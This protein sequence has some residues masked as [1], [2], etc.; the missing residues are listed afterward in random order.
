MSLGFANAGL[1][2]SLAADFEKDACA[3]YQANLGEMIQCLDLAA[4]DAKFMRELSQYKG[5]FALIG[6][7]P[8]QGF[9]SAGL[10]N[11][12][13]ARNKLI[14]SYLN[15]VENIRPRW[16]LFENVEGLLTSNDGHSVAELVK[17]F[18]GVGYRVRLEKINF[19]SYGLPQ[20]RKRVVL[21]GNCVGLDFQMP[22][23]TH[24]YDAG[25]HRTSSQLPLAPSFD[26]ATSGL[27]AAVR[28]NR[29]LAQYTGDVS[30]PYDSLMR[31]GNDQDGVDWHAFDE[32]SAHLLKT[33]RHLGEGQTMKDL[34]E[35]FWHESFRR[36]AFR[37]VSDGTPT[38][39]RGGAPSGLKRLVGKLT[40]LTI[41]SAATREFI[42][43]HE[44]RPLTLRE[45]ARLQS[46]PDRYKFEG[47]TISVARQIGNAFPPLAARLL[48]N[49]LMQLDGMAGGDR[50]SFHVDDNGSLLGFHLT[51]ALGM[52]P[53]LAKTD[54][55]L[56]R[57]ANQQLPFVRNPLMQR[58]A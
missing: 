22:L 27:G 43:P 15:I 7:P 54:F 11:G 3:T 16:F 14:F 25:K 36:R 42:H 33:I 56:S 47:G 39:R 23:A 8:C 29:L 50:R 51:D 4:P 2:P 12:K 26:E 1:K 24:S 52:S 17:N 5:A 49:H 18:I 6:G 10:K 45:S 34:P 57:L 55:M 46:F 31:F 58:I 53:A 32:V 20:A 44:D 13:D 30:S 48:A 35:S 37:R 19:A 28:S 41:T 21:I 38:E 9:S 40:A